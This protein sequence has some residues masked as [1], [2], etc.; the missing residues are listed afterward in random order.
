MGKIIKIR[1]CSLSLSLAS[2]EIRRV[3]VTILT[4]ISLSSF[5]LGPKIILI[6]SP[7]KVLTF[8]STSSSSSVDSVTVCAFSQIQRF[9]LSKMKCSSLV[10]TYTNTLPFDTTS[11]RQASNNFTSRAQSL[12][13]IVIHSLA[14][15]TAVESI[16]LFILTSFHLGQNILTGN[17]L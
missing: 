5:S 1:F 2:P 12:L 11:K 14:K 10:Y 6:F 17:S 16:R 15:T 8:A 4:F 9:R 7:T 13:F 3:L